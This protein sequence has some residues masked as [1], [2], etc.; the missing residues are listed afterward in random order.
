MARAVKKQ[1]LAILFCSLVE[2]KAKRSQIRWEDFI[3][4]ICSTCLVLRVLHVLYTLTFS[5][6]YLFLAIILKV[7]NK[8]EKRAIFDK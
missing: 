8:R 6:F 4:Y 5:L 2:E 7:K 1:P 3:Q